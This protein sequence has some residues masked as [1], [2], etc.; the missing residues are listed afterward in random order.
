MV[1]KLIRKL[2]GFS[3]IPNRGFKDG[4]SKVYKTSNK[5]KLWAVCRYEQVQTQAVLLGRN[6]HDSRKKRLKAL[7]SSKIT[8][9]HSRNHLVTRR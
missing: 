5:Y 8:F 7:Q 3:E 9:I 4:L 2:V 1:Y 6:S